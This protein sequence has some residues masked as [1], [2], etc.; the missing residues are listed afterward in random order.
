MTHPDT[1]HSSADGI[2]WDLGDLYAG[3]DD[4]RIP[5]AE[6]SVATWAETRHY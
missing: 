5:A 6:S 3:P 2:A 4:P 1:P